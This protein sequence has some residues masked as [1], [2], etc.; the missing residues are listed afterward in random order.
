RQV[1]TAFQRYFQTFFGGGQAE[2]LLTRAD[3]EDALAGVDIMAQPP[4]KRVKTLN[5]LSGGERSLTA[6]A[7]LFALLDTNPSPICV[8]DEVDAALDE[9]NV[10][11]FND[12]LQELSERTQFIIITHN[13]RTLEMADTIYGVSMGEDSTSTLLS[14]RISDV[15]VKAGEASFL[16]DPSKSQ[17]AD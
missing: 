1:N 14:L 6:M 8:L 5:M 7:L 12:A 16:A 9:T 17:E 11:R 4:R 13:R 2:L 15:P 3:E 10:G